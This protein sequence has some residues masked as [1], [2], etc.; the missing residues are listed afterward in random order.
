MKKVLVTLL[1]LVI[2]GG[3]GMGAYRWYQNNNQRTQFRTVSMERGDL[4]ATINATGTVE[5]EE[6]IDVGAQVVGQIRSFGRDPR[7][8]SRLIDFGSPVEEGTV[9]AQI[10][11][12]VYASQVEQA[13]A[14]LK[15]AEADLQQLKAKLHQTER[16]WRRAEKM[17]PTKAIAEVDYDTALAVYETAQSALAV[18]EAAVDQ[19]KAS[20]KQAE[21]SLGYCTIR[22]PVK[23]VI[24]DR[25]VNVGQTV[26][27]S[28]NAPSLF[29]LAKDLRRLQIWASVNEADIGNIHPGQ[30]VTFT[31]DAFPN[32][33][34]Q[35]IVA[36]DQPRLNATMT[37]N[38]V[39]YTVVVNTDN[40][41]GKLKPYLTANL[42]FEVD[43]HNNVLLVPNA[44][45]RWQPRPQQVVPEA[46]D[47]YLQ[48]LRKRS[49]GL[50]DGQAAAPGMSPGTPAAKGV[51]PGSAG[52]VAPPKEREHHDRGR[53]WVED[54]G[55]VRPVKVHIGL[56]DGVHTEILGSE[57]K[58]GT[59]VVTGE[60]RANGEGSSSNPFT[61]QMFGG[62]KGQ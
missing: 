35:G 1:A 46:R 39:T 23:G 15:R 58:E 45:L 56:T 43:R 53:L 26:V 50:T 10:D 51:A 24:V 47:E 22:S 32:E 8:S 62:K 27:S 44:A 25:R 30:K 40:A 14:N 21:I 42:D 33:K 48:S 5:P 6:V 9:L 3:G 7:D 28:L 29:L 41:N 4:L 37:Q 11:D 20:L 34:F 16:D 38:V 61:P 13:K 59:P 54:D 17:R 52:N 2:L 36:P 57:L 49:S 55:Y 18:G 60:A 19:A 12:S 31:V